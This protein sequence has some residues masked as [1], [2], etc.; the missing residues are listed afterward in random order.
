MDELLPNGRLDA[1]AGAPAPRS[2]WI[3]SDSTMWQS[4]TWLGAA[5]TVYRFDP[6]TRRTNHRAM[7][8]LRLLRRRS[9]Y[10]AVMTTGNQVA[11]YY[12]LLCRL[13]G[14]DSRQVVTQLYL[15]QRTGITRYLH[16]PLMRLVLRH[17]RGVLVPS[18]GEIDLVAERFNV[19]RERIHF[20]P[21]HT[22][23]TQPVNLGCSS[24]YVFA[25]GRNFRDY[26]TLVDAV[27]D[28]DVETV[29]VCGNDHLR[30][31]ELPP[32]VRVVREIPW[33]EYLALLQGAQVVVVPLSTEVV[34]SGQVAI[35]EAMGYGKPVITTR[36][37]GTVDY[38]EH[39]V[40]GLLYA[41]G[42]AEDLREQ[43]RRITTDTEFRVR[44]G[45]AAFERTLAEF[46]FESHVNRKLQAIQQLAGMRTVGA[47]ASPGDASITSP[48]HRESPGAVSTR[49]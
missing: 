18:S 11:L 12:G 7:L 49:E 42:D 40:D 23:L 5:D 31:R 14:V 28:L 17:A 47:V 8:A 44:M 39:G 15:D 41:L 16:D 9:K 43:L 33:S 26:D 35:L 24:G 2:P 32:N 22:N 19:P 10:D 27:A 25:A 21:Y 37:V 4:P 3:L 36:S 20:I 45:S 13:L 6:P 48:C 46:T 29:I 1:G 34:P 38:V 30:D